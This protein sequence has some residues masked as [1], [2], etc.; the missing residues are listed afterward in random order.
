MWK[1]LPAT[2]WEEDERRNAVET[3]TF[4]T[5]QARERN[6]RHAG[7]GSISGQQVLWG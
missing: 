7:W 6:G 3:V 2:S 5:I 4:V 1:V